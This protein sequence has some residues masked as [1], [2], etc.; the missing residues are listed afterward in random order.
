MEKK[1]ILIIDD[2]E[3]FTKFIKL[4]LEKTEKYEVRTENKGLQ[5]LASAK[6]F[7][8]DLILLDILM[9]DLEGSEVAY[10]LENDKDTEY[11]PV[12]F[13]TAL[14]KKEDVEKSRGVIGGH[15]FIPKTVSLRE[16]IDRIE[17]NIVKW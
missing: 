8:P 4:N 9:P 2:E 10:Q 13:L 15:P 6:E 14:A 7:K 11:I 12:L 16:L 3:N 17:E 5:A 1:K